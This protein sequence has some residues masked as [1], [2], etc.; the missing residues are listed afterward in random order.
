[1][2]ERFLFA[3]ARFLLGVLVWNMVTSF[4]PRH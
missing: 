2:L 3:F 4:Q 1:M